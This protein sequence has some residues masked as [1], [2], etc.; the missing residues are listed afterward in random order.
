M[1]MESL[2]PSEIARLVFGYLEEHGCEKAAQALLEELPELAECAKLRRKGKRIKKKVGDLTL[3]DM[4]Q[5]YS[6]ARDE[7]QEAFDKCQRLFPSAN[8]HDNLYEQIKS[9][10]NFRISGWLKSAQPQ[11]VLCTS[12]EIQRTRTSKLLKF[13]KAKAVIADSSVKQPPNLD[14]NATQIGDLPGCSQSTSDLSYHVGDGD[15]VMPYISETSNVEMSHLNVDSHHMSD[16]VDGNLS[17]C[18]KD[19]KVVGDRMISPGQEM[20]HGSQVTPQKRK[21][22]VRR[23]MSSP[24]SGSPFAEEDFEKILKS[25]YENTALHEK[26]AENINRGLNCTKQIGGV[27]N[28]ET[29]SPH[30][31]PQAQPVSREKEGSSDTF[32]HELDQMVNNIISETTADPIFENLVGDVFVSSS[33]VAST[34]V[35]SI[36]TRQPKTDM[37]HQFVCNLSNS[38]QGDKSDDVCQRNAGGEDIRNKSVMMVPMAGQNSEVRVEIMDGHLHKNE[39]TSL[40]K[41]FHNRSEMFMNPLNSN[42]EGSGPSSSRPRRTCASKMYATKNKTTRKKRQ[43]AA[44]KEAERKLGEDLIR[45]FEEFQSKRPDRVSESETSLLADQGGL[46]SFIEHVDMP[47]LDISGPNEAVECATKKDDI[48]E[49]NEPP[50][51]DKQDYQGDKAGVLQSSGSEVHASLGMLEESKTTLPAEQGPSQCGNQTPTDAA[52]STCGEQLLQSIESQ[53]VQV[54]QSECELGIM[55][56]AG[57]GHGETV[58]ALEVKISAQS[59]ESGNVN[60]GPMVPLSTQQDSGNCVNGSSPHNKVD[61][62]S[63]IGLQPGTVNPKEVTQGEGNDP[64]NLSSPSHVQSVTVKTTTVPGISDTGCTDVIPDS[65]KGSASPYTL[66]ELVPMTLQQQ[67]AFEQFQQVQTAQTFHTFQPAS[68]IVNTDGPSWTP[69]VQ[70]VVESGG[71]NLESQR[72]EENDDTHTSVNASLPQVNTTTEETQ[73]WDSS[74]VVQDQQSTHD[75]SNSSKIKSL[76]LMSVDENGFMK[77]GQIVDI[78]LV[79]DV[80]PKITVLQIKPPSFAENMRKYVPI[81]PK[82]MPDQHNGSSSAGTS[83]ENTL[84]SAG[85]F[86]LPNKVK[87]SIP[88]PAKKAAKVPKKVKMKRK[89]NKKTDVNNDIISRALSFALNSVTPK[90]VSPKGS[91]NA[92]VEET[93]G[94]EAEADCHTQDNSTVDAISTAVSPNIG[95]SSTQ[96]LQQSKEVMEKQ[97]YETSSCHEEDENEKG[98]GSKKNESCLSNMQL[99]PVLKKLLSLSQKL[100]SDD[101]KDGVSKHRSAVKASSPARLQV[102]ARKCRSTPSRKSGQARAVRALDFSTPCKNKSPSRSPSKASVN[103]QFSPK[104][105]G[106]VNT[107]SRSKKDLVV[108]NTPTKTLSHNESTQHETQAE[109]CR[110]KTPVKKTP[111]KVLTEESEHE[112]PTKRTQSKRTVKKLNHSKIDAKHAQKGSEGLSKVSNVSSLVHKGRHVSVVKARMS[113]ATKKIINSRNTSLAMIPEEVEC[114]TSSTH[115]SAVNKN[116]REDD[117]ESLVLQMEEDSEVASQ[118]CNSELHEMS[119]CETSS[120][121]DGVPLKKIE[122]KTGMEMTQETPLKMFDSIKNIDLRPVFD[123]PVI[124]SPSDQCGLGN[125]D[126]NTPVILNMQQDFET[127]KTPRLKDYPQGPYSNSSVA[128]SYYLPSERSITDSDGMTSPRLI[129]DDHSIDNSPVAVAVQQ[130]SDVNSDTSPKKRTSPSKK[131]TSSGRVMG[132]AIEQELDKLFKNTTQQPVQKETKSQEG[133]HGKQTKKRRAPSVNYLNISES[134]CS[135]DELEPTQS[136]S[137]KV[138]N[139]A[140]SSPSELNDSRNRTRLRKRNLLRNDKD[141]HISQEGGKVPKSC[142]EQVNSK[143]LGKVSKQN[144]EEDRGSVQS[145][146]EQDVEGGTSCN[147]TSPKKTVGDGKK[148][149]SVGDMHSR[150]ESGKKN[151]YISPKK[152]PTKKNFVDVFGSDV[153]TSDGECETVPENAVCTKSKVVTNHIENKTKIITDVEDMT[154]NLEVKISGHCSDDSYSSSKENDEKVNA[155]DEEEKLETECSHSK[156]EADI[157]EKPRRS[158]RKFVQT[159]FLNMQSGITTRSKCKNTSGIVLKE[160]SIEVVASSKDL[161]DQNEKNSAQQKELISSKLKQTPSTL[162]GVGGERKGKVTSGKSTR[163]RELQ[164]KDKQERD[165]PAKDIVEGDEESC[166]ESS[167]ES[168]LVPSGSTK[169]KVSPFTLWGSNVRCKDKSYL[170]SSPTKSYTEDLSDRWLKCL[171]SKKSRHSEKAL[172]KD[173]MQNLPD[174]NEWWWK[175]IE[176][177]ESLVMPENDDLVVV[178]SDKKKKKKKKRK[179]EKSK[180]KKGCARLINY[181]T[182]PI[183]KGGTPRHHIRDDGYG[184]M[185]NITPSSR[186]RRRFAEDGQKTP[187]TTESPAKICPRLKLSPAKSPYKGYY[188]TPQKSLFSPRKSIQR[189]IYFLN[190][191][192]YECELRQSPS[193]NCVTPVSETEEHT[194]DPVGADKDSDSCSDEKELSNQCDGSD[195]IKKNTLENYDKAYCEENNETQDDLNESSEAFKNSCESTESSLPLMSAYTETR[196]DENENTVVPESLV[197]SKL[198]DERRLVSPDSVHPLWSEHNHNVK[199]VSLLNSADK[200]HKVQAEDNEATFDKKSK[201]IT[202]K[203]R[204]KNEVISDNIDALKCT[205]ADI[206]KKQSKGIMEGHSHLVSTHEISEGNDE[207]LGSEK[208]VN[209]KPDIHI[210]KDNEAS[211]SVSHSADNIDNHLKKSVDKLKKDLTLIKDVLDKSDISISWENSGEANTEDTREDL[212]NDVITLHGVDTEGNATQVTSHGSKIDKNFWKIDK[213]LAEMHGFI[214]DQNVGTMI[215]PSAELISIGG[216]E[217]GGTNS[218]ENQIRDFI[219][220]ENTATG[221]IEKENFVTCEKPEQDDTQ[222]HS[223]LIRE[224]GG[225]ILKAENTHLKDIGSGNNKELKAAAEL[226]GSL[227][228]SPKQCQNS[229]SPQESSRSDHLGNT[230][231]NEEDERSDEADLRREYNEENKRHDKKRM[232]FMPVKGIPL[233]GNGANSKQGE[234][235]KSSSGSEFS[236]EECPSPSDTDNLLTFTPLPNTPSK[237]VARICRDIVKEKCAMVAFPSESPLKQNI[238]SKSPVRGIVAVPVNREKACVEPID[239]SNR[240]V[241][242]HQESNA[243]DSV[244]R[245]R[246]YEV[247]SDEIKELPCSKVRRILDLSA[248]GDKSDWEGKG[249]EVEEEKEEEEEESVVHEMKYCNPDLSSRCF[250]PGSTSLSL[251]LVEKG[252]RAGEDD[253]SDW[254]KT[255]NQNSLVNLNSIYLDDSLE[256]G[257]TGRVIEEI[258]DEYEIKEDHL[259]VTPFINILTMN[260]EETPQEELHKEKRKKHCKRRSKNKTPKNT[261]EKLCKSSYVQDTEE[262]DH[263]KSRMIDRSE[264]VNWCLRSRSKSLSNMNEKASKEESGSSCAQTKI[265]DKRRKR[266]HSSP[267]IP[268]TKC[269]KQNQSWQQLSEKDVLNKKDLNKKQTLGYEDKELKESDFKDSAQKKKKEQSSSWHEIQPDS[270]ATNES[271]F[272]LEVAHE[273]CDDV[274][275]KMEPGSSDKVETRL[276]QKKY[277]M[278]EFYKDTRESQNLVID[279]EANLTQG[280]LKDGQDSASP[281]SVESSSSFSQD[282]QKLLLSSAPQEVCYLLESESSIEATETEDKRQRH[283]RQLSQILKSGSS[284]EIAKSP[285]KQL[286]IINTHE[287]FEAYFFT[288]DES[289]HSSFPPT[290]GKFFVSSQT[291]PSTS[292]TTAVLSSTES[293]AQNPTKPEESAIASATSLTSPSPAQTS[294]LLPSTQS[295]PQNST[296]PQRGNPSSSADS[297]ERLPAPHGLPPKKRKF[298]ATEPQLSKGAPVS[299]RQALKVLSKMK[300]LE[301]FLNKVHRP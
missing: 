38:S 259:Y 159:K 219:D 276:K 49:T 79:E 24:K 77:E 106:S 165:I 224:K 8:K 273:S 61:F 257:G 232:S 254:Q 28:A 191:K 43:T 5:D 229:T 87:M 277:A 127:S 289:N 264:S 126:L 63:D 15:P 221:C 51:S 176:N 23:R 291:C 183:F 297:N 160:V 7:I 22:Q 249:Q 187:S 94:A 35:S 131:Y 88:G 134:T 29:L 124:C 192:E 121:E 253:R 265:H 275:E 288:P 114:Q 116:D 284:L 272:N 298:M 67:E 128:T 141:K 246:A 125:N 258:S 78:P 86:V 239:L 243:T 269:G 143:C 85:N 156:T 179:K 76:Y 82:L 74:T 162:E 46:C 177:D 241:E 163:R 149:K 142:S 62:N 97:L 32:V 138:R 244:K 13:H 65:M 202:S 225:K 130:L 36:S 172:K 129:M 240:L 27:E 174:G 218:L 256:S 170:S 96:E 109:A 266:T 103:L 140:K 182:S 299:K 68:Y 233:E 69:Y 123:T 178:H 31:I 21:G 228:V 168:S 111:K 295:P 211:G 227:I 122:K 11:G 90:K 1:R 194:N 42:T 50:K 92:A 2:L 270:G 171:G 135:E 64:L 89:T 151:R 207:V 83:T 230:P 73:N 98:E 108:K 137:A 10:L 81:Q 72:K 91:D 59:N 107:P 197:E 180:K 212:Q 55:G 195:E 56:H 220:E 133:S 252:H 95:E 290:P 217:S 3:I 99:S 209:D 238:G 12:S 26:I 66:T 144:L 282:K 268:I 104:T 105:L 154:E 283:P 145:C 101:L 169:S 164:I 14:V 216:K 279:Q 60:I 40:G 263:W 120:N 274:M 292:Q 262:P 147:T 75:T 6:A 234:K 47:S 206:T 30:A 155:V 293:S 242:V 18:S 198:A 158:N 58:A 280:D 286:A 152:S 110:N 17:R 161:E 247:K 118:S 250:E 196:N 45:E 136:G 185:V 294:I 201:C 41:P 267:T 139:K 150:T 251:E 193:G 53:G 181:K 19:D 210:F 117:E 146:H 33:P 203:R 226:G 34:H 271:T 113:P 235:E 54:D 25:L 300:D 115:L 214:S 287:Q 84:D 278:K 4:L 70:G 186:R 204:G 48:C 166:A 248:S 9:L 132:K 93:A 39:L 153:S 175:M 173:I 261:P 190:R 102:S 260:L 281:V 71:D 16:M 205:E 100:S 222:C 245:K 20:A 189:S 301:T 80:A 231:Q 215:K 167:S 44:E 213:Q 223:L 255:K 208:S 188:A 52:S 184:E 236:I 199:D 200:Q 112:T 296:K 119:V 57:E 37:L 237:E 285:Q 148:G 157:K